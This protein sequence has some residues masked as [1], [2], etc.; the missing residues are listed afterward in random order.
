[1]FS[2]RINRLGTNVLWLVG[3]RLFRITVGVFVLGYIARYL[4]TAR[5]GDLNYAIG[6]TAIFASIATLGIEGIVIRELVKTPERTELILGTACVLRLMGGSLAIGLLFLAS[7][8]AMNSSAAP[9][10]VVIS[11]AFVPQ[12]FEVIDLWFQKNIQSKFT[13]LAKGI[14]VLLGAAVKI[15]LVQMEAPLLWFAGA[16]VL[17]AILSAITLII[18]YH[19]R[20]QTVRRWAVSRE[21]ARL[22]LRDSWPLIL[23]A[24]LVSIYMRIEQILVMNVL[25]SASVGIY[26]AS[27]RITEMWLFI[28]TYILSTIYPVLVDKRQADPAGYRARLQNVF[29]LLTGLGYLVAVSVTALAPLLIPLIYGATF[30]SAIPILMIQ[31][32]TAPIIFSGSVRA[33]YFLLEN[34]TIYHTWSALIGIVT[35]A[36]LALWLMPR[37]G[38]RGAA[39]AALIGYIV[40]SY[41]T[42]LWFGQLRECGSIQTKAFLLPFRLPALLRTIR[43]R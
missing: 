14:A 12:A 26:Y 8:T 13:V 23:S 43:R 42:S 20:G 11:L 31:A 1:M 17:D 39:I 18:V 38:A 41:F 21:V 32:W 2:Q 29:D 16:L 35:N 22:I 36:A 27:A 34:L 33:Q 40:S 3:D 30:N 10:I 6:L 5:F 25:G 24:L 4:G 37:I 7:W 9:I 28:P 19:L 15:A